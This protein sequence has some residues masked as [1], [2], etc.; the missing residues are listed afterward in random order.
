MSTLLH[1]GTVDGLLTAVARA[2]DAP[3]G[4]MAVHAAADWQPALFETPERVAADPDRAQALL[5]ELRRRGSRRTVHTVFHAAMAEES[6]I[7]TAL[8]A[9]VRHVRRL[10]A[11]ASGYLA[12]PAVARVH[13]TARA[14]GRETHRL[15][16]LV[17]FRRLREGLLWAPVSPDHNVLLPLGLFFKARMPAERWLLHD[18]RRRLAIRWNGDDLDWIDPDDLPA[19]TPELADDESAYQRLW[20]TYFRTI[21]VRERR[22]PRLQRQFMPIRYWKHLVEQPSRKG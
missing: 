17:R 21:A 12:D 15:K 1:D 13:E 11:E 10:G 3:E 14:V 6:D 9:Y 5:A 7:G 18:V 20:Q 2:A 8:A 19:E 22:N 16:G 4:R